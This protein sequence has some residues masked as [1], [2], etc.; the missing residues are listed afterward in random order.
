M[1]YNVRLHD[2]QG[3]FI[4]EVPVSTSPGLLR[5][6]KVRFEG[7]CSGGPPSL[8]G[9]AKFFVRERETLDF[10]A[11]GANATEYVEV[12]DIVLATPRELNAQR[13]LPPDPTAVTPEQLIEEAQKLAQEIYGLPDHLLRERLAA[14]RSTNPTMHAMVTARGKDMRPPGTPRKV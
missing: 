12:K 10:F 6:I 2:E 11:V 13:E 3:K 7:E 5:F 4:G 9:E 14:L 1:P 8:F